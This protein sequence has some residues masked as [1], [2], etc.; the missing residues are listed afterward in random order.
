MVILVRSVYANPSQCQL[1]ISDDTSA[2]LFVVQGVELG[3]TPFSR[4][5][6]YSA[7]RQMGEGREH[8]LSLLFL[9]RLL[10]KMIYQDGICWGGHILIPLLSLLLP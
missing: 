9:K 7:L 5:N 4:E 1:P 10:L 3:G 6:L 2:L 8:F